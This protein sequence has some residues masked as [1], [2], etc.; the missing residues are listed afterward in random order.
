[1][2]A[3]GVARAEE[4]SVENNEDPRPALEKQGSKQ[5]AAP[6]ENLKESDNRHGG[7]IVLLH[8][9]ANPISPRVANS[10]LALSG[11]G[12]GGR[13]E[14]G[15]QVGTC[16]GRNVEDRVYGVRK[17]SEGVLGGEEPDQGQNYN[18]YPRLAK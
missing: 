11:N 12:S 9:G 5:D 18:P 10:G 3:L 17:E 14:G 4:C 8:K 6:E 15:D 16:V 1:M 13:L 2:R 7:V